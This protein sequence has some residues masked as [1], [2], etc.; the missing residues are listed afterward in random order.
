MGA[1]LVPL[2][3]VTMTE[4]AVV[5]VSTVIP[6]PGMRLRSPDDVATV[7]PPG[8]VMFVRADSVPP[9]V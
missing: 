7:I 2:V 5:V 8:I 1:M 9:D 6:D 3:A 4:P